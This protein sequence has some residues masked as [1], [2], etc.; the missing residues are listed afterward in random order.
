MEMRISEPM[1]TQ[2]PMTRGLCLSIH[3]LASSA[4]EEPSHLP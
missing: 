4:K 3:S 1:P 2:R